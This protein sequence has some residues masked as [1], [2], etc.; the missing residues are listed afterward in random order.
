MIRMVMPRAGKR[1]IL[2]CFIAIAAIAACGEKNGATYQ[3]Y[4]EGEYVR[5]AAPFAGT[6]GHAYVPVVVEIDGASLLAGGQ[7]PA[8]E[9]DAPQHAGSS[10]V[11]RAQPRAVAAWDRGADRSGPGSARGAVWASVPRP[12]NGRRLLIR[13]PPARSA[14]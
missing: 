12:L 3:G 8:A 2:P 5:V 7:E 10:A 6:A 11:E 14:A 13:G 9:G 4:A 1:R